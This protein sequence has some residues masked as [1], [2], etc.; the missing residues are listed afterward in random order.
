LT[1]LLAR[2]LVVSVRLLLTGRSAV[3]WRSESR[4]T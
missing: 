4:R 1:E 2:L 3:G